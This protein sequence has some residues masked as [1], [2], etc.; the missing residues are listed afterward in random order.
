MLF[1][2][3]ISQHTGPDGKGEYG[4]YRQSERTHIYRQYV[5]KLVESGHVYRCFCTDEELEAMREE[6]KVKALPPR[7]MGKWGSASQAEIDVELEKGTP[8]TFRFRVPQEG[9][10]TIQDLIRGE[11]CIHLVH[12]FKY[13]SSDRTI[14]FPFLSI[15]LP[16]A[17]VL[18][19]LRNLGL[20]VIRYHGAKTHWEILW[21]FAAMDSLSTTSALLLMMPPC[22]SLMSS[23][24][25]LIFYT[26][27][28]SNDMMLYLSNLNQP[29]IVAD[30][31]SMYYS[32]LW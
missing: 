11:V 16:M 24:S 22:T 13:I 17:S 21:C 9:S 6:A 10:V 30:I 29:N 23:G 3:V 5:D 15:H 19:S 25:V 8:Y 26:L 4:P 28:I 27:C 1:W 14:E 32:S 12:G 2:F 18:D 20:S 7:Y 31:C